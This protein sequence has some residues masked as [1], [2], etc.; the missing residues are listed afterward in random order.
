[1]ND[2]TN[3]RVQEFEENGYVII[4][5]VV[6]P[7]LIRD[8]DR[9]LSEMQGKVESRQLRGMHLFED[10]EKARV[11]FNPYDYSPALRSIVGRDDLIELAKALIGGPVQLHHSKLMV[12]PAKR[13]TEQPWHQDFFYWQGKEQRQVAGFLC[14][15]P[16]TKENGCLQV[17]PGT[18]KNGLREHHKEFHE[19]TGERHWVCEV[20][21]KE[22]QE[23]QYFEG[24]PGDMI[25]FS[26]MVLH[27]SDPNKSENSRRAVI[28]EYDLKDNLDP[29]PIAG[30][31]PAVVWE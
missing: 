14:I 16:S 20:K 21:D 31:I 13:G 11:V 7:G 29:L 15:D 25:F 18:H 24:E 17:I 6:E 10:E 1:M 8:L 12:K 28:F 23:I 2:T 3:N 27:A 19:I 5:G 9:E 26:S 4:R 22:L 30:P